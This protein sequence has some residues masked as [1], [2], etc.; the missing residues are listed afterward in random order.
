MLS[1]CFITNLPYLSF[2]HRELF[3]T[4]LQISF[5]IWVEQKEIKSSGLL[6][7]VVFFLKLNDKLCK[8][9]QSNLPTSIKMFASSGAVAVILLSSLSFRSICSTTSLKKLP[10][11]D[12]FII[13]CLL[14]FCF[15]FVSRP[16]GLLFFLS[17]IRF[18]WFWFCNLRFLASPSSDFAKI[19][20]VVVPTLDS[21]DFF[22]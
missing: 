21:F 12:C 16:I 4:S 1:F 15:R 5:V 2:N 10:V 17:K 22:Q 7:V 13:N 8:S 20:L 18:C 19:N 9:T 11:G 3:V 6:N 14:C